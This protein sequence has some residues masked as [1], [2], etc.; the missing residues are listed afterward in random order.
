MARQMSEIE[1]VAVEMLT[2]ALHEAMVPSG[3]LQEWAR[4]VI[5]SPDYRTFA[6]GE[7]AQGEGPDGYTRATALNEAARILAGEIVNY[8]YR[9]SLELEEGEAQAITAELIHQ[10]AMYPARVHRAHYV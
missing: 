6:S 2:K 7:A 8:R 9:M 4:H 10:I 5:A 3:A 1:S